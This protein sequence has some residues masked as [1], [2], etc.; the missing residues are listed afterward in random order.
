[1]SEH[2]QARVAELEQAL[3]ASQAASAKVV[4]EQQHTDAQARRAH[5]LEQLDDQRT[6]LLRAVTH[7]LRTPLAA[8]RA[9][10]GDIRDEV[11]DQVTQTR[12][13]T[14]V[15]DECDRLDR[16]VTN[17]LSLSRIEARAFEPRPQAMDLDEAI[18]ERIDRLLPL[19]RDHVIQL[20]VPDDLPLVNADYGQVD[21]VL[22]NVLANAV[23]YAPKGS[24]ISV[25]ACVDQ[26]S[27]NQVR[28]EIC[29]HG[30]GIAEADRERVFEVFHRGIASRGSG[31]GLA[32]CRAIVDANQ[33]RIWADRSPFGGATVIF[34]LPFHTGLLP[35]QPSQ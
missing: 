28:V 23:H 13:L 9:A 19:L 31:I 16:L 17:L 24:E 10:A 30:P 8:I 22:T 3:A 2:L 20:D 18:L 4:S 12:M 1:M 34:T 15:C 21:Q 5:D 35:E 33:G 25:T 26:L 11:H 32:V 29:D 14:L 6:A 7:D 27:T